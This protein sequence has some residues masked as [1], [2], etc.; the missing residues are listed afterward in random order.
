[1]A[2]HIKAPPAG[3]TWGG[4]PYLQPG[5]GCDAAQRGAPAAGQLERHEGAQAAHGAH[6][7]VAEAAGLAE[8][9]LAQRGEAA[10]RGVEVV[11]AAVDVE[12]REARE[13]R[14]VARR[15]AGH[16]QVH[17]AQRGEA[18]ERLEARRKG[19]ANA[20]VCEA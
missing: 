3:N 10:Q 11:G 12:V 19:V 5:E 4:P 2:A 6:V 1:M 16:V 15:A 17:A 18:R 9:E 8:V 13:W 14:E 7:V 20:Q